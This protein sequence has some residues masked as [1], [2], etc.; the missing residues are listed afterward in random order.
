MCSCWSR[1]YLFEKIRIHVMWTVL[2]GPCHCGGQS[3]RERET[4][5]SLQS[6]TWE[7]TN[8]YIQRNVGKRHF[9]KFRI[10]VSYLRFDKQSCDRSMLVVILRRQSMTL[11][12]RDDE[13]VP[14][15]VCVRYPAAVSCC[16]FER[17]GRIRDSRLYMGRR[18]VRW[19]HF[20]ITSPSW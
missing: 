12:A 3:F 15:Y 2:L 16:Y 20:Y 11:D 4:N 1:N 13:N 19:R 10:Y 14:Q 8:W 9:T 17:S 5:I 7:N 18:N 6:C